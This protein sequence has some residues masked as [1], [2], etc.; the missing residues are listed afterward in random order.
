A[1]GSALH[2]FLGAQKQLVFSGEVTAIEQEYQPGARKTR[3]RAYDLLARLRK[4]Y[5]VKAHVQVSVR[6]L[7]S[8]MMRALGVSVAG[9]ANTPLWQRL[10]QY[11]QSDLDC[12]LDLAERAGVFLTLRGDVL[13]LLTLEGDGSSKKLRLGRELLEAS[14][15]INRN[16]LC[17]SASVQ[18]W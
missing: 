1:Y 10:I 11:R 16:D 3:I 18:G 5:S 2:L 7:A 12:L 15:Q 13:Q 8:D 17:E 6:D 9:S 4:Q 14:L